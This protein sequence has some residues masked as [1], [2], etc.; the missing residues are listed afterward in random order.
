MFKA[1]FDE[2][3]DQHQKIIFVV[4]GMVGRYEQWEKIE[5]RW[6]LLLEKYGIEY[7]RASEAEFAR[8]EFDK[9]PYR[10][11]EEPNTKEQM[12]LLNAVKEEFFEVLTHGIVSGIT[13]GIPLQIFKSI[14]NT[15]EKLDKFG[16]TPYFLCAHVAILRLLKEQKDTLL[17]KELIAFVFDR[18]PQFDAE[19]L[20]VHAHLQ[21]PESEHRSRV[22]SLTFDD[23]RRFIPL[24]VAD[25]LVFESRKYLEKLIASP[26][27]KPRPELQRLMDEGKIFEI[28]LCEKECL[29]WYLEH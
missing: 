16:G 28:T 23:K 7:Y 19:T 3:I 24:Q 8:G 17:S 2:S 15:P 27:T 10:T 20:K 22:G 14:A 12:A 18:Q 5:W 13:I 25:T 11:S 6:K 29:E 1:Y 21:S 26:D 9:E 4:G